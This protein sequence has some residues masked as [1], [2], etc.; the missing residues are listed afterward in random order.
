MTATNGFA[1]RRS[2]SPRYDVTVIGA[3]RVVT[4]SRGYSPSAGLIAATAAAA[5]DR[6]YRSALDGDDDDD[7]DDAGGRGR[8]GRRGGSSRLANDISWTSKYLSVDQPRSGRSTSPSTYSVY[9]PA[10]V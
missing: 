6:R 2:I 1:L 4:A 8:S 10:V 9:R 3:R 5:A 7:D